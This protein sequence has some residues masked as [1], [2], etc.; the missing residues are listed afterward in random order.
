MYKGAN[1][2]HAFNTPL[3]VEGIRDLIKSLQESADSK[4][5]NA[6][7]R[8][9]NKQAAE[10]IAD[11]AAPRAPRGEGYKKAG[12]LSRRKNYY[13]LNDRWLAELRVG[14]RKYSPRRGTAGHVGAY[15]GIVHFGT[16]KGLLGRKRPW[17]WQ[18]FN[19]KY[20][21]F[22]KHYEVEIPKIVQK[23]ADKRTIKTK[24]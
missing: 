3:Q 11:E 4:E 6:A 9:L 13:A 18:A 19:T 12:D 2:D 7:F 20:E 17:V 1:Q 21:D 22:T 10:M 14:G 15:S 24:N 8:S 16:G 5:V 23:F